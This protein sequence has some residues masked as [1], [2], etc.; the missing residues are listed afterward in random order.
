[1]Y[2]VMTGVMA[3]ILGDHVERKELLPPEQKALRRGRRGCRDAITIDTAVA[4]EA[5]V[6]ERDLSVAWVD[7]RKAFESQQTRG[8]NP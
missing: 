3:E 6:H 4:R 8:R 2:K 5:Q 7:Y 1:M